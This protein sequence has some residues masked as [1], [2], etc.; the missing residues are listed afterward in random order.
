MSI[1]T[2]KYTV[3]GVAKMAEKANRRQEDTPFTTPNA[4]GNVWPKQC[5]PV[6]IPRE[7]AAVGLDECWYCR[8]ADFHLDR[9]RALDVGICCWP[10]K[11]M[12]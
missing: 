9:P 5:C 12:K 8:H 7:G 4:E 6:F 11:V 3:E 10:E 2:L 1:I